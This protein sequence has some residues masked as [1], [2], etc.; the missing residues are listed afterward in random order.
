M[1]QSTHASVD[2]DTRY[3]WR[4]CA[5]SIPAILI[6]IALL[7]TLVVARLDAS[8][9]S[10]AH[11][12][13]P[14]YPNA[15]FVTET[16]SLFAPWGLGETIRVLATKDDLRTVR[17]WYRR[18]SE[19]PFQSGVT[20]GVDNAAIVWSVRTIGDE[21]RILLGAACGQGFT[22]GWHNYIDDPVAA[23]DSVV[24]LRRHSGS[25]SSHIGPYHSRSYL[26]YSMIP[27]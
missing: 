8:C 21:T 22:P 5:W 1:N 20:H 23:P 13:L 9:R 18:R 6:G 2:N 16:Y 3:T 17:S 15:T 27:L 10:T 11:A 7:S 19:T 12:A 24:F 26:S 25:H 14:D 4:G